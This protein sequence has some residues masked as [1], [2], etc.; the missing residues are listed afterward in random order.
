MK[1]SLISA[2]S[3]VNEHPTLWQDRLPA[4]FKARGPRTVSGPN[5]G[6]GWVLDE[7]GDAHLGP[8]MLGP[9]AVVYRST[10]R[11]DRAQF[12]KR[13]EEYRDGYNRPVTYDDILPGSFDPAA[14]LNEMAEDG[15]TAEVLYNSVLIWAR[16]KTLKDEKLKLAC[17]Q[18]Y[19][20]WMAEFQA[21]CPERLIG[22][23]LVPSTGIED[24]IAETK[25]CV[26][27]LKLKTV[28]LESW[29][30]G[31]LFDPSPADDQFW[32]YAAD[33]GIPVDVHIG[34]AI[35]STLGRPQAESNGVREA[36]SQ[37][38]PSA[39]SRFIGVMSSMIRN[40]VFERFPK[41]KFVGAEVNAGWVP[42]YLERFDTLFKVAPH[43]GPEKL[44]LLPSDY[45]RRNVHVTFLPDYV[46]VK[47][48]HM[49]GLENM[50][51]SSDFPHSVSN[52]PIDGEIA[53]D[54]MIKGAVPEDEADKLLWKN[55]AD[56]YH[57]PYEA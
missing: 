46:G 42:D 48:R 44:S 51:W 50:M 23:G 38:D 27:E 5:G 43:S 33:A 18:A 29:P 26:D 53:R 7:A 9:T 21:H 57:I 8:I 2:D 14:R 34:Y 3:H 13:F 17:F 45:F 25:R 52:W 28:M 10:K 40:G 37:T 11:Y 47:S 56:L 49:I 30:N 24:A 16:I 32:G 55:C 15:V 20:D 54:Q 39:R 6:D 36:R 4:K 41:L 31:S 35:P 1:Y 22:I 12:R 19:N